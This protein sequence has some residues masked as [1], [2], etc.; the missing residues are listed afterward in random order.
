[1]IVENKKH[2]IISWTFFLLTVQ[3][4]NTSFNLIRT[5]VSLV[6]ISIIFNLLKK[7][8]D[9]NL[10][11]NISLFLGILGHLQTILIIAVFNLKRII[12]YLIK[13]ITKLSVNKKSILIFIF[14]I[15]L[16][17]ILMTYYDQT[18][19]SYL[20]RAYRRQSLEKYT[21]AY[22]FPLMF[23]WISSI[24]Y[25]KNLTLE[26]ESTNLNQ[27]FVKDWIL[28][29]WLG[30]ILSILGFPLLFEYMVLLIPLCF[31]LSLVLVSYQVI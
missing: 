21:I 13:T 16:F 28:V 18:I 29:G 6:I 10:R 17:F 20:E 15:S 23:T 31:R 27:L 8:K 11:T 22:F 4:F 19:F 1:L 5:S 7:F 25:K 2:A 30:W 24:I 14:F 9:I 3:G 12:L 26:N